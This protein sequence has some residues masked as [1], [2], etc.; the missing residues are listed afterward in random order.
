MKMFNFIG[1]C[2][3]KISN[4]RKIQNQNSPNQNYKLWVTLRGYSIA[5]LWMEVYKGTEKKSTKKFHLSRVNLPV[6]L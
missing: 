5:A 1:H 4:H 3:L 2:C 6:S